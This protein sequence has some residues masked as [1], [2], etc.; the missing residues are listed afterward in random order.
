MPPR[1]QSKPD[2]IPAG[3]YCRE[4]LQVAWK[5]SESQTKRLLAD[6]V[7]N[8]DATLKMFRAKRPTGIFKMPFYK[9]K[10]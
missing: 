3:Y 6:A 9:F 2:K 5:L 7:R 10:N 8:K 1:P 4:Q